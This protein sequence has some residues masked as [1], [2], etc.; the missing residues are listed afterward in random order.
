MLFQQ[1]F[2]PSLSP[3]NYLTWSN[4]SGHN[5]CK[6]SHCSCNNYLNTQWKVPHISVWHIRC[7]SSRCRFSVHRSCIKSHV[8]LPLITLCF[9]V[10]KSVDNRYNGLGRD[11][12]I[13][14]FSYFLSYFVLPATCTAT[15]KSLI[16]YFIVSPNPINTWH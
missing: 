8:T 5:L 16:M 2:Y 4:T 14:I 11:M 13:F 9:I 12:H 1:D 7:L 15:A 6:N 10:T 3:Y